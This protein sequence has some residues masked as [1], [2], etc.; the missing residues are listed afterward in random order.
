MA[1]KSML[2]LGF[3]FK[4]PIDLTIDVGALVMGH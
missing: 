1:T 4:K 2:G 3:W